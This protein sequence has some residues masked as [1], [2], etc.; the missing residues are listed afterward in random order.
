[1]HVRYVPLC[2]TFAVLVRLVFTRSLSFSGAFA[3]CSSGVLSSVPS[4]PPLHL[5]DPSASSSA[6]PASALCPSAAP[7]TA[8]HASLPPRDWGDV[9]DPPPPAPPSASV[10]G[11]VSYLA[12]VSLPPGGGRTRSDTQHSVGTCY[13][14]VIVLHDHTSHHLLCCAP[15]GV[16]GGNICLHP[17]RDCEVQAHS[18]P[19]CWKPWLVGIYFRA[20]PRE[21]IS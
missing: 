8:S 15:I 10:S 18:S 12:L 3:R 21:N 6:S 17:I 1:M 9:L 20:P 13:K 4:L 7:V 16:E 11:L 19:G 14:S 5:P 2:C